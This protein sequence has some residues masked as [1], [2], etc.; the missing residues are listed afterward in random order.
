MTEMLFSTRI[1]TTRTNTMRATLII[2]IAVITTSISSGQEILN[3]KTAWY[4]AKATDELNNNQEIDLK[5][6]FIINRKSTIQWEQNAGAKI[7]NFTILSVDSQWVN[8]EQNGI[9]RYDVESRGKRGIITVGRVNN[10]LE[11]SM[12]FIQDGA[13]TMPFTFK[14]ERFEIL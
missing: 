5:S 11:I 7:Y 13:N 3:Q 14:I 6:T 2:L 1:I 8:T 10:I 9:I 12:E 4:S